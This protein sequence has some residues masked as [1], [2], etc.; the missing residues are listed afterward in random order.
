MGNLYLTH[1]VLVS[2]L[3]DAVT[4]LYRTISLWGKNN[5]KIIMIKIY[6][7][8]SVCKKSEVEVLVHNDAYIFPSKGFEVGF[9][10]EHLYELTKLP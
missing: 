4:V 6:I 8:S 2:T 3:V 5:K 7:L 1:A 10:G 9:K